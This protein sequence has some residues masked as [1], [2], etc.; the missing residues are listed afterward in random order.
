M[1]HKTNAFFG[2][3]ILLIL[4]SCNQ[5]FFKKVKI[6]ASPELRVNLGEKEVKVDDFVKKEDIQKNIQNL[7]KDLNQIKIYEYTS[8]EDKNKVIHYLLHYPINEK[9]VDMS[10]YIQ[11]MKNLPSEKTKDINSQEIKIP[12]IEIKK[13]KGL[14]VS[15][16]ANPAASDTELPSDIK[17]I[18]IPDFETDIT[19]SEANFKKAV[20]Y[21]GTLT[22]SIQASTT[23][24]LPEG[25]TIDYTGIKVTKTNGIDN[26]S[27]GNFTNKPEEKAGIFNLA[28][29]TISEGEKITIGGT[30]K[31][32]GS[33]TQGYEGSGELKLNISSNIKKFSEITI[34]K[35]LD[36]EYS[37]TH[38]LD[39]DLKD[40][41]EWIDFK[42]ISAYVELTNNLP[43][44]NDIG[45]NL[46]STAFDI[47]ASHTFKTSGQSNT[48]KHTMFEKNYR[49]NTQNSSLDFKAVLQPLGYDNSTTGDETLT[50]KNITPD[51]TYSL[52]GHAA[53]MFEWEKALIK[54]KDSNKIGL[55]DKY[56]KEP[57]KLEI[58]N[59]NKFLGKIIPKE[60][61]AYI[62]LNSDIA[63]KDDK[64]K[65]LADI[66]LEYKPKEQ[67]SFS[68]IDIIEENNKEVG[69]TKT[70]DLSQEASSASLSTAS[71]SKNNIDLKDIFEKQA[72]SIQFSVN[73][74]VNE[75]IITKTKMLEIDQ[76]ADK[77]ATFNTDIIFDIPSDIRVRETIKE[78]VFSINDI[79]LRNQSDENINEIIDT[80]KEINF[81]MKYNNQTG[82]SINGEISNPDWVDEKNNLKFTKLA[83]LKQGEH[84]INI[85]IT[86]EEIDKIKQQNPFKIDINL[87]VPKSTQQLYKDGKLKFM[88]YIKIGTHI[89]KEF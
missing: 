51:T 45:V 78:K 18:D 65:L 55:N 88:T 76:K 56:P 30:L 67:V 34:K 11:K 70:P 22:V 85:K 35:K 36:I 73:F 39:T 54:P 38:N 29:K 86:K 57:M 10:E 60:T 72:E 15:I 87:I 40:F 77:S 89:E 3:L 59:K 69:F 12:K 52:E 24:G 41:V 1:K 58:F 9:K 49:L 8:N 48:E 23:N 53:V 26:V 16:P 46:K 43:Q 33:L 75:M 63:E 44:G 71:M 74:K 20:I 19:S 79:L 6:I 28:G 42:S 84:E 83:E 7:G 4:S 82:I 14:G 81:V 50:I 21:E 61:A 80:T 13:E 62:F 17:N 37:L 32:N 31:I 64:P 2:I 27:L 5:N 25:I 68:S 66:K 47:D